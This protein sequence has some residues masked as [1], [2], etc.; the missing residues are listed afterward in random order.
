MTLLESARDLLRR[1]SLVE[2]VQAIQLA[3]RLR[4]R[5]WPNEA[6]ASLLIQT[7]AGVYIMAFVD[8]NNVELAEECLGIIDNLNSVG[9]GLH[10]RVTIL[11]QAVDIW[12]VTQDP[13]ALRVLKRL[14]QET[15]R[16]SEKF[17]DE[18]LIA[19]CEYYAALAVE[20]DF[21]QWEA[22]LK[23][24]SQRL[25]R[26][27]RKVTESSREHGMLKR[28]LSQ[29]KVLAHFY[30]D[31]GLHSSGSDVFAA[32]LHLSERVDDAEGAILANLYLGEQA[33]ERM[34]GPAADQYLQVALALANDE[35]ES[36]TATG[37]WLRRIHWARLRNTRL[38]DEQEHI[39]GSLQLCLLR[40]G[41]D[42]ALLGDWERLCA[43]QERSGVPG[44]AEESYKNFI[45]FARRVGY[46]EQEFTATYGLA[47]L[48]FEGGDWK[49]AREHFTEALRLSSD[50]VDSELYIVELNA[51][52]EILDTRSDPNSAK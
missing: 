40:I 46:E 25:E 50:W 9:I 17:P 41:D 19:V 38:L 7:A 42:R 29:Y 1:N 48:E 34:D 30:A 52:L 16:I 14:A 22:L 5:E 43:A 37:R 2:A 13:L 28:A 3:I 20:E 35:F 32:M 6:E 47:R 39:L 12:Q 24:S 31:N 8:A 4:S 21:H 44:Q 11:D 45:A 33:L 23:T 49:A 51:Y 36:D 15:L 18:S 26:S 10:T 27:A